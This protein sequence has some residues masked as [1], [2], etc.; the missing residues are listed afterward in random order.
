MKPVVE[1]LAAAPGLLDALWAA[2][3]SIDWSRFKYADQTHDDWNYGYTAQ[4]I[5]DRFKDVVPALVETWDLAPMRLK[6]ATQRVK[7]TFQQ[8]VVRAGK[9]VLVKEE[10]EIDEPL[11]DALPIEDED[12]NPVMVE[13]SPG[14]MKQAQQLVPRMRES[15]DSE[16]LAVYHEDLKNIALALQAYA[17]RRI[18][19]LEAR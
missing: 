10:I 3:A 13:T 12:G 8:V 5:R 11:F 1:S 15:T 9:C 7:R 16:L 6:H 18:E 4:E 17:M 14:E 2:F 19:A